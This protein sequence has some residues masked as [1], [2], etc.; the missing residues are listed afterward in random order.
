M[1][2]AT[3]TKK[4]TGLALFGHADDLE[5]LHETIHYLCDAPN[6]AADQHEHALS[7]AYEIRKAFERQ[8]ETRKSPSGTQFGTRFVWPH[9]IFYTSYLRQLAAY[10]PTN[11]EHQ[12][13]LARLEYC[14]ES[15]LVGYDPKVG[16]EVVSIYPS[17]G[18]VTPD[19]LDGYVTDVAY[20]YLYEGGSGKLRFRRLPALIRSMAQWSPEYLEYSA[21]L[22]REAKKHGCSPHELHD[23]REWPDIEW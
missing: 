11:K 6:G 3:P 9:I 10:R 22:E 7:V 18:A 4:G 16:S 15:A 21:M 13:N 12:S 19:F 23:S 20:S 1:L 5:N 17:I 2:H 8:R 14:V